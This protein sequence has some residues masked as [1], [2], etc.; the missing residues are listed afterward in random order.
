MFN[1]VF[2]YSKLPNYWHILIKN[3]TDIIGFSHDDSEF[4]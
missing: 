4:L 1:T 2:T 3:W